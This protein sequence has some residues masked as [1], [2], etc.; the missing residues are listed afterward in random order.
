MHEII[1][2][3]PSDWA[4]SAHVDIK[5][6]QDMYRRSVEDP[7]GFWREQAARLDRGLASHSVDLKTY[8]SARFHY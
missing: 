7:D 6:Y 1:H 2:A 8:G 3:V 5:T 4:A